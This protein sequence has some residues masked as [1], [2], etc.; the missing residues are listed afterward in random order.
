MPV[1]ICYVAAVQNNNAEFLQSLSITM[2]WEAP[3][4]QFTIMR[5]VLCCCAAAR[6]AVNAA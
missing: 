5:M 1:T 4:A 3:P 2:E 6:G